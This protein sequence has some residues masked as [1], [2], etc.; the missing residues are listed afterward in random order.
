MS[1]WLISRRI[2]ASGICGLAADCSGEQFSEAADN[3]LHETWDQV[4]LGLDDRGY[5][6]AVRQGD[7]WI[8]IAGGINRQDVLAEAVL[9][10]VRAKK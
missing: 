6:V 2:E 5:E 3:W 4:K 9:F 8:T 7:D 10:S 1:D